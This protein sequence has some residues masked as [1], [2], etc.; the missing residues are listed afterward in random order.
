MENWGKRGR[1]YEWDKWALRLR[2]LWYLAQVYFVTDVSQTV[3]VRQIYMVDNISCAWPLNWMARARVYGMHPII[4]FSSNIH[5]DV[6]LKMCFPSTRCVKLGNK[7]HKWHNKHIWA[8]THKDTHTHTHTHTH[9]VSD[10]CDLTKNRWPNKL[11]LP[12]N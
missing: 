7:M 9:D 2:L 5:V 4:A 8:H 3:Y 12:D 1:Q 6:F 11:A 10:S